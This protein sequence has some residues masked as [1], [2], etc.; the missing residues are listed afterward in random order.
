MDRIAVVGNS[1]TGKTFVARQLAQRLQVPHTE[2]D[3]IFHQPGWTELDITEFRRR[4]GVLVAE[5]RWVIDGN[6][7]QVRDL[8]WARAD[9]VVW[10]DLPR[11]LVLRR[12]MWRTIRRVFTRQVLWNGNRERLRN[13]LSWHPE[14]SIIRWSWTQHSEYRERYAAAMQDP[15]HDHLTFHRLRTPA[16][17]MSFLAR[18]GDRPRSVRGVVSSPR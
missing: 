18:E 12:V 10:L 7:K 6:Y 17:V 15:A 1:G 11:T 13:A 16:Q 4:V 14:R 5:P 2:L 8:V 3:S 9:T